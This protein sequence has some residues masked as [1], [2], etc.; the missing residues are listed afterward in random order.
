MF[1]GAHK[2]I[3]LIIKFYLYKKNKQTSQDCG[4]QNEEAC[5]FT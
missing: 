3:L 5:N 4:N 2:T 1:D